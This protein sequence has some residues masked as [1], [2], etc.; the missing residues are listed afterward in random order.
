MTARRRKRGRGSSP[1]RDPTA[2]RNAELL[3]RVRAAL[4][5]AQSRRIVLRFLHSPVETLGEE[6]GAVT[7]VRVARNESAPARTASCARS[8]PASKTTI[9][10]GLAIRSI[11]TRQRRWQGVPFDERRDNPH[12]GGRVRGEMGRALAGAYATGWI[13]R[14]PSGVIGTN[15]KDAADT[16]ARVVEDRDAASAQRAGGRQSA[17]PSRR[18]WRRSRP[19]SSPGRA[20]PRSTNKSALIA[21]PAGARA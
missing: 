4:H 6:H 20:G 9:D 10:C 7:G 13:K 16:V 14:G 3:P 12:D 11:D 21:A 1:W 17:T 2:R 8:R 5:A 19:D 15:K 18:T